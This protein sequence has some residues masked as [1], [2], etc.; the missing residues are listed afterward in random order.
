MTRNKIGIIGLG[1]VG[2]PLAI[3]FSK[4][5]DVIGFDS[6][7]K[8]IL[9]LKL[10]KDITNETTKN[11]ILKSNVLF[12]SN[13]N[14][15]YNC[16]YFIIA[17]PTPV[18]KMKK[19][20]LSAVISATRMVSQLIKKNDIIVYESTVYPGVTEEICV[21]II[22]RISKL[23]FNR[24]FFCGYS[25]ER[26]NPSDKKHKLQNIIKIVSGSNSKTANK[27]EKLYSQII[28]AGIHKVSSIKIAEAAKVIENIQRDLNISLINELTII[29]N[30]LEID[31]EEVI[32]A[33]S[34]KWNFMKFSPGLVGGHCIGIDP[35]YLIHKANKIGI[36]SK[37]IAAGRKINSFMPY[38][39][40]NQLMMMYKKKNL[41]LMNS[42]ILILGFTFKENCS[43]TRHT[44]VY[45]I[46]K[47][48]SKRGVST[49]IY[50]PVADPLDTK[51]E[52]GIKI[53]SKQIKQNYYDAVI[54]AVAHNQFRKLGI[55]KIR[56]YCRRN[57]IIYDLKHIFKKNDV[58]LRL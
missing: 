20:D 24:D 2:L 52:H 22:E 29:F 54:L 4:K 57:S 46:Y 8:R 30:K 31:T 15:L 58:D 7:K 18:N 14:D 16:K 40:V 1:Y 41:K 34:T 17:V 33:A 43:D 23:K 44:Q 5:N 28:K 21:P 27:L 9:D 13:I 51:K 48:L 25:P 55:K 3:A 50:D 19:P 49:D 56:K 10:G 42:K 45:E 26:I 36:N 12:S 6:K 37:V 32:N 38:H 53:I 39:V 11:D 47:L 35:Y